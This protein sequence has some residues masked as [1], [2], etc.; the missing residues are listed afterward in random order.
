LARGKASPGFMIKRSNSSVPYVLGKS[1][2]VRFVTAVPTKILSSES[3]FSL[4]RSARTTS[5]RLPKADSFSYL[6]LGST[7]PGCR[8]AGEISLPAGL[9]RLSV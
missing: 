6:S 7:R 4:L 3:T 9:E 2:R 5:S 1:I 8:L